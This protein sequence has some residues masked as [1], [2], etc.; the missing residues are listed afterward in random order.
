MS[1]LCLIVLSA[2]GIAVAAYVKANTMITELGS[3]LGPD[4]LGLATG[5]VFDLRDIL[6]NSNKMTAQLAAISQQANAILTDSRPLVGQALNTSSS[7][8]ARLDDFSKH[9][10]LSIGGLG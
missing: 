1:T 10:T 5:A 6:D 3:A 2:V 8:L 4:P 9:P 7:I